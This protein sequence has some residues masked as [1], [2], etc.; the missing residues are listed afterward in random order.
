MCSFSTSVGT[1]GGWRTEDQM[2]VHD[3][4][5]I[6]WEVVNSTGMDWDIFTSKLRPRSCTWVVCWASYVNQSVRYVHACYKHQLLKKTFRSLCDRDGADF[7]V[8]QSGSFQSIPL[9][10]EICFICFSLNATLREIVNRNIFQCLQNHCKNLN[11]YANL[12]F[13]FW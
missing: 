12:Q 1:W 9:K 2:V 4:D 6:N 8:R 10:M 11:L 3:E 7:T 5:I 13:S